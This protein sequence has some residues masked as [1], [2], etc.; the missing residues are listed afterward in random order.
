MNFLHLLFLKDS[1]YLSILEE[2]LPHVL[3]TF[4]P[5]LVLY[6]AGVD[7]HIKDELG[8]LNLSDQGKYY[9]FFDDESLENSVRYL[10]NAEIESVKEKKTGKEIILFTISNGVS[11]IDK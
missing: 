5:D 10:C 2:H 4:R 7:P 9:R 6:D 11:A 1:A 3:N 8:H